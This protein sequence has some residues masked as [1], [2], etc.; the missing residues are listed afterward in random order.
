VN[1]KFIKQD[2]SGIVVVVRKAALAGA[3]EIEE[4]YEPVTNR[5]QVDVRKTKKKGA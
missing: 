2:E 4:S 5:I 1:I 3:R